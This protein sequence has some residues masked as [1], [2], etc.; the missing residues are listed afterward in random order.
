[1]L[2]RVGDV[3]VDDSSGTGSTSGRPC[4]CGGA[5]RSRR[6]RARRCCRSGQAHVT[7]RAHAVDEVVHP[8]DA[9]QQGALAAARGPIRSR[10]LALGDGQADVVERLLGPVPEAEGIHFEHG[11]LGGH[12]GVHGRRG[13]S[14]RRR[15]AARRSGRLS[16]AACGVIAIPSSN[17]RGSLELGAAGTAPRRVRSQIAAALSMMTIDHQQQGGGEDHGLG[18]LDCSG[19][20][21]PTS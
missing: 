8:V 10:D 1:M 6:R 7:G 12:L 15:V 18:G 16:V 3:V 2:Q 13:R 20:W 21:N 17:L 19:D 5:V 4:P 14:R 9:A 11:V